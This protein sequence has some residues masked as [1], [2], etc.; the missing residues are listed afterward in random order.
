MLKNAPQDF[1]NFHSSWKM[2]G[3]KDGD[4]CFNSVAFLLI[5]N[6]DETVHLLHPQLDSTSMEVLGMQLWHLAVNE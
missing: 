1:D 3:Q 5:E 2:K 4:S 6:L